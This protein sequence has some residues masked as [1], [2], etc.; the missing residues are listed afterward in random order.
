MIKPEIEEL[1]I[2]LTELQK[3]HQ[4]EEAALRK[5]KFKIETEVENWIHKYDQELEEKQ[6]ELE[7]TAA[8]YKEEKGQLEELESK[9]GELSKEYDRI[10]EEKR[11]EAEMLRKVQEMFAKQSKAATKIQALWRGRMVRSD[12]KKKQQKAGVSHM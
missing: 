4:E 7:E 5:K 2:K 11:Q 6:N 10:Q 1:K 12:I 8:I 9:F 3:V